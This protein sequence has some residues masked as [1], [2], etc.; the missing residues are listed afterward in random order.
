MRVFA[1]SDIHVDYQENEQWLLELSFIDYQNDILILAG[2]LTDDIELLERCFSNLSKKFQNVLF[3]PGNHDLWVSR[4][5]IATSVV[6]YQKVCELANIYDI[7]MQTYQT[8]PLS[9]I[10]LLGWYDFSFGDPSIQLKNSWMDFRSCVWPEGW[11]ISDVVNYFLNQNNISLKTNS[12]TV[13][14]FSHF[15]PRIDLM[16]AYI[17]SS[18]RYLYPVLGS[19]L[20]EEQIRKLKPRIHVYGH[21]HVNRQIEIK[22]IKYINNAFGYPSE[23]RIVNKELLCIYER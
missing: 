13:I 11:E 19:V 15:L 17:P 4:D 16:P 14:T 23:R 12:E 10:P 3:V 5:T 9:I 8:D 22:E 18:L 2:D 6:K 21:S 20:I 7:S 1:L